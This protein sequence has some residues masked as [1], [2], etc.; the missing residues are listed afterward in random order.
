MHFN[1]SVI[2]T[3]LIAVYLA[4]A[5]PSSAQRPQDETP[6]PPMVIPRQPADD[7]LKPHLLNDRLD[8]SFCVYPDEAVRNA[9]EGCCRMKVVIGADGRAG[10][11]A[12]ECTHP[13]FLEPSTACLVPQTYLPA[14]RKGKPIRSTGDIVVEFSLEAESPSIFDFLGLFRKA[15]PSPEREHDICKR[16]P[17]DL[18]ANLARR[19]NG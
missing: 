4:M 6:P 13:I 12:G 2:Q 1:Q 19:N 8:H 18:I 14:L 15:K 11:I 3:A 9:I 10:K 16:R 17:D 5:S 7:R